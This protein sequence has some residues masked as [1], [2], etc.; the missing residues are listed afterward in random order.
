MYIYTYESNLS[1]PIM[2]LYS[3]EYVLKRVALLNWNFEGNGFSLLVL[4]QMIVGR[5]VRS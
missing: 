4:D 3:K 2:R 5:H 1:V